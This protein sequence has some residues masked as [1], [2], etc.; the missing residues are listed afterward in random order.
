MVENERMVSIVIPYFNR[1]KKLI[2]C[3]ESIKNQTYVNYE[4]I[5]VD[6]CSDT[7]FPD[8]DC[9]Y[10]YLR[11]EINK[12]PGASRNAGMEIAKGDYV[13]FL[14]SDD[15]WDTKFLEI[16]LNAFNKDQ[17]GVEKAVFAYCNTINFDNSKDFQKRRRKRIN[18]QTILPNIL[19]KGRD[20]STSSCL[21]NFNI[22]KNERWE[23]LYNWEDYVFDI[24]IASKYNQ[25]IPVDL[26]LVYYDIV[27]NDKLSNQ[28]N[29]K[30]INEKSKALFHIISYMENSTFFNNDMRRKLRQM[31]LSNCIQAYCHVLNPNVIYCRNINSLRVVSSV[32]FVFIIRMTLKSNSSLG[33]RLLSYLKKTSE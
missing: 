3:V 19:S 14:D 5:I 16:M 22:I 10:K 18:Q 12:G 23:N 28:A 33:L 1:P 26:D 20:W 11:N 4:I 30:I 21:W 7:V 25:I 17:T 24:R 15:Y 29:N 6:D 13:A 32:L 27:G 2:R 8:L 31:V 9:D